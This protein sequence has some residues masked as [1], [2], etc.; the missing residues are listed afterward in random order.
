MSNKPVIVTL[1]TDPDAVCEQWWNARQDF[2]TNS[3]FTFRI[4]DEAGNTVSLKAEVWNIDEKPQI[5]LNG[6]S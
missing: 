5:E 1:G 3:Y 6:N 2:Y 4:R